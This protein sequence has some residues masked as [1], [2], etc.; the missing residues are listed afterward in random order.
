MDIRITPT[1]LQGSVEAVSSKS[2]A[3]RIMIMAAL[4]QSPTH[5][6]LNSTNDDM[7]ATARCMAALG[8]GVEIQD[9]G[10]LLT[11]GTVPAQAPLL[12]C[13]ES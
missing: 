3:H 9:D 5:L 11:P 13:G 4:C 10:M 7:T 6:L 2:A 8:C 12:Q 1:K